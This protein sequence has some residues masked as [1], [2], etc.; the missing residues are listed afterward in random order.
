MKMWCDI[1]EDY[2]EVMEHE[3]KE[4]GSIMDEDIF[5]CIACMGLIKVKLFNEEHFWTKA[6]PENT[7]IK[8]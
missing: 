7:E 5:E 2:Q 8:K 4:S 6:I 3:V 1:C